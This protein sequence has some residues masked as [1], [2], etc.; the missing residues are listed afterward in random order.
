MASLGACIRLP[1][2]RASACSDHVHTSVSGLPRKSLADAHSHKRLRLGPLGHVQLHRLHSPRRGTPSAGCL[3]LRARPAQHSFLRSDP[4]LPQVRQSSGE[5]S[6][7]RPEGH[8][9]GRLR[10]EGSSGGPLGPQPN[11][12]RAALLCLCHVSINKLVRNDTSF[13]N[14]SLGAANSFP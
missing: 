14:N 2:Q 6:L 7:P 10:K 11:S 8:R 12:S 4:G 3:C 1:E 13:L 5:Q 9:E